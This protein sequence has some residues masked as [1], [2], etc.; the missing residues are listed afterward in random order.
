MST[1]TFSYNVSAPSK[2]IE[3]LSPDSINESAKTF[4]VTTDLTE[5]EYRN[6]A[7]RRLGVYD[8]SSQI[9]FGGQANFDSE[10][11]DRK[12]S[13]YPGVTAKVPVGAI[14][15]EGFYNRIL[16]AAQLPKAMLPLVTISSSAGRKKVSG[17]E[18]GLV[19]IDCDHFGAT[20]EDVDR[21]L[22]CPYAILAVHSP[23]LD[24]VK[25]V[26]K[27]ETGAGSSESIFAAMNWFSNFF[28]LKIF[29]SAKKGGKCIDRASLNVVQLT[30]I[31]QGRYVAYKKGEVITAPRMSYTEVDCIEENARIIA[32]A[33]EIAAEGCGRHDSLIN[34]VA[35]MTKKGASL[36][37]IKSALPERESDP[38]EIDRIY[39]G[40]QEYKYTAWRGLVRET[41]FD[42]YT[43]CC[44]AVKARFMA[45]FRV[46]E[47][48]RSTLYCLDGSEW[49]AAKTEHLLKLTKNL[50]RTQM[51][52][53]SISV[54]A[55]L[56]NTGAYDYMSKRV[57]DFSKPAD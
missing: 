20:M 46:A 8:V 5:G 57:V 55:A 43:E 15:L 33:D 30:Y 53:S 6:Y 14:S 21:A 44:E 51:G 40:Q 39:A 32:P 4:T 28:G 56:A 18:T 10:Y 19:C 52:M 13:Y 31:P 49:P 7:N 3:K 27:V 35:K 48:S 2:I 11:S 34:A 50:Y 38:E 1:Y 24:G 12:F 17:Q 47:D 16:N 45:Q 37:Q 26:C 22:D 42:S 9:N 41:P 54:E 25:V 36:E 29:K 23:S